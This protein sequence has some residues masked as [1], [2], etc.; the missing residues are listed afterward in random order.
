MCR[1]LVLVLSLL[2]ERHCCAA[3]EL[4]STPM[5]DI[6]NLPPLQL[7]QDALHSMA[8]DMASCVA[9]RRARGDWTHAIAV[10]PA[11]MRVTTGL[12]PLLSTND[13]EQQRKLEEIVAQFC[14]PRTV[15]RVFVTQR[16]LQ[17]CRQRCTSRARAAHA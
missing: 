16:S 4:V 14:R 5:G 3:C 17:R 2:L 1:Q 12:M 9:S 13:H 11:A 7:S 6:S 15:S 8:V 10:W